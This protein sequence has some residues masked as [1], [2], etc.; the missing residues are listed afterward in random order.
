MSG[1]RVIIGN[2]TAPGGALKAF[3]RSWTVEFDYSPMAEHVEDGLITWMQRARTVLGLTAAVW[4]VVAYPLS[5]GGGEFVLGKL[6]ELGLSCGILAVGSV[7]GITA[8]LVASTPDRR[9][10]FAER[11]RRPMSAAF[12]LVSGPACMWL[13]FTT[14][15]GD[16]ISGG[17]LKE[18]FSAITGS[19]FFSSVLAFLVLVVGWIAALVLLLGSSFFTLVSALAC[20]LVCLRVADVHQLLPALISPLLVWSLF[21]FQVFTGPDVAAPPEVLY[22]FML[23]GPLSVTALSVW[24]VRRLRI[25]YGI[26]L[27]T[28]LGR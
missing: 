21:A 23:G 2:R 12:L 5:G 1:T 15:K 9:R 4:L 11:L 24:E 20:V 17:D 25:R 10:D 16:L 22:T 27:R 13:S 6:V 18:F 14:L 28:A 19:G 3:F 7:I 8:F 26:T